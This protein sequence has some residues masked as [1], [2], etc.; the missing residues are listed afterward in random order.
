MSL[1]IIIVFK[2]LTINMRTVSTI[3]IIF[4]RLIIQPNNKTIQTHTIQFVEKKFT[5]PNSLLSCHSDPSLGQQSLGFLV[6]NI[7]FCSD[8]ATIWTLSY[9]YRSGYYVK[10]VLIMIQSRKY[11][12]SFSKI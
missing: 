1:C 12:C 8:L 6:L 7:I 9:L 11:K 3:K 4:F 10:S 2:L 5:V